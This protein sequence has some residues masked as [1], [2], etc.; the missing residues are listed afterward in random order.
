[1]FTLPTATD[2]TATETNT[3]AEAEPET[4]F[5]GER[6]EEYEDYWKAISM[7]RL[8]KKS[9]KALGVAKV[10]DQGRS[11]WADHYG[12]FAAIAYGTD[13]E[14]GLKTTCQELDGNLPAY[15]EEFETPEG[16]F[17]VITKD[18]AEDFGL[19]A[20]EFGEDEDPIYVPVDYEAPTEVWFAEEGEEIDAETVKE[21]CETVNRVGDAT[22]EELTE[23][24]KDAGMK[25]VW[26]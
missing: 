17:D 15:K 25:V 18:N 24:L 3:E 23:A 7:V 6:V 26:A 1:M 4:I 14:P 20:D 5:N 21:T 16:E 8:L 19:P 9:C 11:P 12:H 22:A 2:S 10:K 13:D